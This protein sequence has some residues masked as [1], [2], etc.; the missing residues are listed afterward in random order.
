MADPGTVVVP[1][2]GI[3]G[4]EIVLRKENSYTGVTITLGPEWASWLD[5]SYD[6]YLTAKARYT[7]DNTSNFFDVTCDIDDAP[8]GVISANLTVA[9]VDIDPG[10]DYWWQVQI[11]KTDGSEVKTPVTGKLT[12]LP[13]VR[14]VEVIP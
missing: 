7:E 5:G 13:L 4:D 3:R 6:I 11:R 2:A 8:N 12:I 1:G 10:Q 14:D 9:N